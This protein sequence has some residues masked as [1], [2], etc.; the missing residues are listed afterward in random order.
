MTF[1]DTGKLIIGSR[2]DPAKRPQIDTG[3][4]Q[5]IL[6]MNEN[7]ATTAA[8][9]GFFNDHSDLYA[10]PHHIKGLA[11]HRSKNTARF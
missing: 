6:E 11:L 7:K 3:W 2:Y 1:T 5:I 4:Q 9:S 8:K 10:L